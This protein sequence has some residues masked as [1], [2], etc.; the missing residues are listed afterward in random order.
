LEDHHEHERKK[1]W[2]RTAAVLA[3]GNAHARRKFEYAL[4]SD[5]VRAA[6]LMVLWGRLYEIESKA[7]E[8]NYDPAQLLHARQTQARPIFAEIKPLLE[9]Y[10]HQVLPKSPM[11]KA[12]GYALNQWEA[13][14]RYID[15]PQLDI[16]NNISE[17]ALRMVVL[18]RKNYLFAG[19]E[20]GAQRAAIIYSLVA[21]CKMHQID[22][23]AYFTDVLKR[24]S[25]HPADKI[26]ELLPGGWKKSYLQSTAAAAPSEVA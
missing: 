19:S 25:T 21:S 8:E 4:D 14:I 6:R 2:Y 3:D 23:L 20:A 11:G 22:P 26:D 13:L 7:K 1:L 18:G 10:K 5:P 16:D 17:Q 9:E 24:V 15:D 12:V